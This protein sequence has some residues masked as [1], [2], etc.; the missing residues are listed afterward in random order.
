M[1]LSTNG[2]MHVRELLNLSFLLDGIFAPRMPLHR[3]GV[4][5]DVDRAS[6][7]PTGHDLLQVKVF[8]LG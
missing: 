6:G 5:M 4:R 2:L 8:E 1:T 7:Q 3:T